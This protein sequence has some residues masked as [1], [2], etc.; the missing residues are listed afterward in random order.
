M[1]P[2]LE[3]FYEQL[4]QYHLILFILTQAL[5]TTNAFRTNKFFNCATETLT[6]SLYNIRMIA[7]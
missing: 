1:K 2:L 7:T 4:L 3:D 5:I 6:V